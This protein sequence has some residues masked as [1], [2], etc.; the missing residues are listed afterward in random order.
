MTSYVDHPLEYAACLSDYEPD[1]PSATVCDA[2]AAKACCFDL[3]SRG[4][5]LES[6]YFL[7]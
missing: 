2:K 4:S 6:G 3:V 7:E 1:W 5:C